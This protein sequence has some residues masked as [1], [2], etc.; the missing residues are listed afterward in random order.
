MAHGRHRDGTTSRLLTVLDKSKLKDRP[1]T[2]IR[3]RP[4]L[5]AVI[6]NNG[7]T[8]RQPHTHALRLGGI[9]S[10]KDLF[11]ILPVDPDTGVLHRDEQFVGFIFTGS[12]KKVSRSIYDFT[13]RFNAVHH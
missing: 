12:N 9:E 11:E 3:H 7:A 6:L 5:S 13:H 8:D 2:L 4:Q 10:I 1:R